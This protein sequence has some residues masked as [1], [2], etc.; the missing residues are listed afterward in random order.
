MFIQ[1]AFQC[2]LLTFVLI[3]DYQGLRLFVLM[4]ELQ[5]S[6]VGT[7]SVYVVPCDIKNR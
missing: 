5:T 7:I 4:R 2:E 1:Y 6:K 3:P